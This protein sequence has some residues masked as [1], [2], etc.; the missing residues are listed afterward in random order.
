ML[1]WRFNAP[2]LGVFLMCYGYSP[3]MGVVGVCGE[4]FPAGIR[5]C[6]VWV[7]LSKFYVG[8]DSKIDALEFEVPEGLIQIDIISISDIQG[9]DT[10]VG[11]GG[12]GGAVPWRL[13]FVIHLLP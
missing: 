5:M 3:L 1:S 10:D 8:D 4:D 12:G 7:F 6:M 9:T 2:V 11:G 13:P